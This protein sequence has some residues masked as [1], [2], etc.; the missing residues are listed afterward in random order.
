M[1]D[2]LKF[3]VIEFNS[4]SGGIWRHTPDKPNYL[5]DPKTEIDTT[6]FGCYVSALEGEHIPLR[7][8]I[9]GPLAKSS[10]PVIYYR[11]I[12]HKLLR[13]YPNNYS[14]D[15]FKQ[16][17]AVIIV[18][19]I[20]NGP[21]ITAF[22]KRLKSIYPH[23]I[24]LGVPTQP[25]GILVDHWNKY[26]AAKTD[27]IQFMD[28][29]D[30]FLT[31][32]KSLEE[33]WPAMSSTPAPYM[34][35]PYPVEYA[36]R[37]FQPPAAKQ[38]IIFIAGVTSRTNILKGHQVAVNL[39]RQFPDHQ[40]QLTKIPDLPLDLS[41]IK[42]TNHKII[43]FEPW[44]EHLEYLSRVK[45][46]INTDYTQTRGRVQVDCAAVGTPSIGA[47][48]DGQVD[49]FPNQP[50]YSD[51]SIHDLVTQAS[52]LIEDS[53]LYQQVT[54]YASQKIHTYNYKNSAARLTKF[55]ES[56]KL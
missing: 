40:I 33:I 5:A 17:T 32:V 53:D 41:I 48:S 18:H 19:E 28:I 47:D 4:K 51:T 46:V 45:L 12:Y 3:A 14:L 50:A 11:K 9:I 49:L 2:P 16:F 15:Y 44:I 34:P 37:N 29:C 30:G 43:P 21:D 1:P 36:L 42:N 20:A 25:Y 35:Q 55:I 52:H 31:L 7:P 54:S 23:L 26:P 24:I 38:P 13:R 27:F 22:T 8:F 39:Q 56:L 10:P 6:S